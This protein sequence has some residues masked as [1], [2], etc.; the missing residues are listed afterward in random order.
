[1]RPTSG[2]AARRLNAKGG[3]IEEFE[4]P[5]TVPT[6]AILF[7]GAVLFNSL[8]VVPHSIVALILRLD[9]WLL[10]AAMAALGLSTHFD[11]LRRTGGR[12]LLLTFILFLWL[13]A[14]GAA[15]NRIIELYAG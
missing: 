9:N 13:V 1:L 11:T 4:C 6:F 7:I 10:A 15:I 12:P 2:R 5:V 14:G 3:A 8:D